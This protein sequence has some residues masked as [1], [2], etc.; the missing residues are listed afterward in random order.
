MLYW[1]VTGRDNLMISTTYMENFE[2][3]FGKSMKRCEFNGV[4]LE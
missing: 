2:T 4:D 1:S 3:N